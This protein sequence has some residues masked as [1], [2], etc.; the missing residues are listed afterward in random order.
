MEKTF[1]LFFGETD[2][3]IHTPYTQRVVPY[4]VLSIASRT[5]HDI[6]APLSPVK[7]ALIPTAS[8]S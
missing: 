4:V 2:D 3:K 7:S 5:C 8:R 1:F 6:S